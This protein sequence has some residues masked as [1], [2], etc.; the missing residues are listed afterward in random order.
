[1]VLKLNG[2]EICTSK[3]SYD[4]KNGINGMSS[5]DKPIRVKKGDLL[6]MESLYDIVKHPMRK[7]TMGGSSGDII[8]GH[9]VMAMMSMSIAL[10]GDK[11]A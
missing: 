9:D 3:A 2:E 8:G 5:C 1:M 10:D 4:E 7:N 11:K 6:A